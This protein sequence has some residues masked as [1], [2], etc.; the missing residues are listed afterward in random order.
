MPSE[1]DEQPVTCPEPNPVAEIGHLLSASIDL[2]GPCTPLPALYEEVLRVWRG[3]PVRTA[4]FQE[5][6]ALIAKL[7]RWPAW[8][9]ALWTLLHATEVS[10]ETRLLAATVLAQVRSPFSGDLSF[11]ATADEEFVAIAMVTSAEHSEWYRDCLDRWCAEDHGGEMPTLLPLVCFIGELHAGTL[12]DIRFARCVLQARVLD[13]EIAPHRPFRRLHRLLDYLHLSDD[14]R[15]YQAYRRLAADIWPMATVENWAQWRWVTVPGGPELLQRALAAMAAGD[16]SLMRLHEVKYAPLPSV[17]AVLSELPAEMRMLIHWLRTDL[18][19]DETEALR[20]MRASNQ[21]ATVA[22]YQRP[23]WWEAW[24]RDDY[25]TVR[26]VLAHLQEVPLPLQSPTQ[27]HAWLERYLI[28]AYRQMSV[29]LLLAQTAVGEDTTALVA[30]AEE[31][32][33]PAIRA[34]GM[35]PAPTERVINLLRERQRHG[36]RPVQLAARAALDQ[37]AQRHGLPGA[38][39]LE[40]QHLMTAAWQLGPLDGERVRVGWQEGIYRLR[41]ETHAGTV[42]L[43]VLGPRGPVTRIPPELRRSGAYREAR[44]AQREAQAQYRLFKQYLEQ[45]LLDRRPLAWG[46]FRYLLANPLFAHLAERLVWQSA[47]GVAFLW[48]GPDRWETADGDAIDL[49]GMDGSFTVTLA[50]PVSLAQGGMLVRWQAIA[51][52][53]RLMQPFKQLFREIYLPDDAQGLVC[54]RFAHRRIDPRR[55]YAILRA[56]G[57]APGAGIARREWSGGVTAHLCWA[58]DAVSHDLFGPQRKAEVMTGDIWFSCGE[59]RMAFA[60]VDPIIFSETLRAADLLTTRAAVGDADL[61]SRETVTLRATL[62][63]EIARSFDQTNIA[64]PEDGPYALVLGVHATYRVNLAS[65]T[66]LLEPEGRQILLPQ[67]DAPWQPVEGSDTTSEILAT[68]LTL[69]HDDTIGDLTF[70]AQLSSKM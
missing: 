40:R 8:Q 11:V 28:P 35:L 66:V 51:A 36:I 26:A 38:A 20:W 70:L 23:C 47:D 44:Q 32:N 9:E 63:R 68:V 34:L 69:A 21:A 4:R 39:E 54:T 48:A 1:R 55:A 30:L 18:A 53:R 10:R 65:G 29:N 57:F 6:L 15:V 59:E 3:F 42:Q 67:P 17:R 14:A 5:L 27:R 61:T 60:Q 43:E 24:V 33:L 12:D 46:E 62:L 25:P 41:L 50:H 49:A 58:S 37:L 31:E 64:V 56:A 22:A 52:D 2:L 13:P 45:L 16:Y 7:E 19:R